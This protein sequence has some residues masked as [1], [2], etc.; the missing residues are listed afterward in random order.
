MDNSTKIF[1]GALCVGGV[2]ILLSQRQK[3]RKKFFQ[4]TPNI[5]KPVNNSVIAPINSVIAP[6]N[7]QI[8]DDFIE[9]HNHPNDGYMFGALKQAKNYLRS[10]GLHQVPPNVQYNT[11]ALLHYVVQIGANPAD[12]I[13]SPDSGVR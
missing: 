6:I 13:N 2:L 1:V 10:K 7:K 4:A 8:I 3:L 5:S 11:P 9:K 12:L